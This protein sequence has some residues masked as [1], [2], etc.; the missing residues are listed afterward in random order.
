MTSML[1]VNFLWPLKRKQLGR[2]EIKHW[3]KKFQK[4]RILGALALSSKN[5]S[6]IRA[7][8]QCGQSIQ[9]T[10]VASNLALKYFILIHILKKMK[11]I[12]INNLCEINSN[13]YQ[14]KKIY[15]E[16]FKR[17]SKIFCS[18][19]HT[20]FFVFIP[21]PCPHRST[22]F[23]PLGASWTAKPLIC[24][25]VSVF[26]STSCPWERVCWSNLWCHPQK[27]PHTMWANNPSFCSCLWWE[28][29]SECMSDRVLG[30]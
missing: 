25:T 13:N 5:A 7:C 26:R 27:Y 15:I 4:L 18:T 28:I 17:N 11:F 12:Q 19:R 9:N 22:S 6:G 2:Q 14:R 23:C 3:E 29:Y 21:S 30:Y 16:I 10:K 24:M 1:R 20:C 8:F